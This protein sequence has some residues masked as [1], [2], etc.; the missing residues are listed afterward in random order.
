[1]C[2]WSVK[3]NHLPASAT[4]NFDCLLTVDVGLQEVQR[5][6]WDK[7]SLV[8]GIF[9]CFKVPVCWETMNLQWFFAEKLSAAG[10]YKGQKC[11]LPDADVRSRSWVTFKTDS[12]PSSPHRYRYTSIKVEKKGIWSKKCLK[13]QRPRGLQEPCNCV[14]C[15][16]R[17]N[18]CYI[19]ICTN[20]E[21]QRM[22]HTKGKHLTSISKSCLSGRKD[23][24]HPAL[25]SMSSEPRELLTKSTFILSTLALRLLIYEWFFFFGT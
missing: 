1:M 21:S 24:S 23:G 13:S 9:C 14:G 4:V 8:K 6:P 10:F 19:L 7:P 20:R 5:S 12:S 3:C 2:I 15:D 22:F 16:F 25:G 18:S 11:H 17:G